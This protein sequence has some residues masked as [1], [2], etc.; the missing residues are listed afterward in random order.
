MLCNAIIPQVIGGLKVFLKNV[1]NCQCWRIRDCWLLAHP[2]TYRKVWRTF[3]DNFKSF[4]AFGFIFSVHLLN[5]ICGL[6]LFTYIFIN[7]NKHLDS[8]QNEKSLLFKFLEWSD[9]NFL[10][11]T[12]QAA[13][14]PA[15]F[16]LRT[17]EV[18]TP[19]LIEF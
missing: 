1:G 7:K 12:I 10:P 11:K 3:F 2:W 18:G 5:L 6:L 14:Y 15:L 13:F 17:S 19:S 9:Q 4:Y 8:S 16:Y